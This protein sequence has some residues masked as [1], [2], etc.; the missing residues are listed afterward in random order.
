MKSSLQGPGTARRMIGGWLCLVAVV[1][2]W[3][4]L[5][6]SAWQASEMACCYRNECPVH[7]H[8]AGKHSGKS[9]AAAKENAP[10][11]CGHENPTGLMACRMSCCQD[12]SHSFVAAVMFLLPEPAVISLPLESA[13]VVSASRAKIISHWFE[14]PSPPPRGVL[15]VA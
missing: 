12:Q 1:L 7:G 15:S 6:A 2:L 13:T 10:I 5:W 14:P 11:E 3:A 9:Q 4:P 8:A